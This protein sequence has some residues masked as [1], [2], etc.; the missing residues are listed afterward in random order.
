MSPWLAFCL[1]W[2][3]GAAVM[4]IAVGIIVWRSEG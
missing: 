2:S 1:G 4:G 3:L